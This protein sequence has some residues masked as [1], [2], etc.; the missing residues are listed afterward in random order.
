MISSSLG[1]FGRV[2]KVYVNIYGFSMLVVSLCVV[3]KYIL[4]L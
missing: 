4:N 2:N 3:E 1:I